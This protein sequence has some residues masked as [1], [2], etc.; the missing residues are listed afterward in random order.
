MATIE[1]DLVVTFNG[2]IYNYP[3]LRA[4]LETQGHRFLTDCDTEVLLHGYRAWGKDLPRRLTGMFA[5]ALADRSHDEL[6]VAR[7]RFGE[8]PLFLLTCGTYVAFASELRPLAAFPDLSRRVNVE[9]L[10][11]YLA[12]NYVPGNATLLAGVERLPAASWRLYSRS[13]SIGGRYWATPM[14]TVPDAN[15]PHEEVLAEFQSRFDRA[16]RLSLRSDV[17]VGLFLSGGV[18]SSLVAESATRQGNLNCAYCIDF[19]ERTHSEAEGARL[20][21]DRLGLPLDCVTLTPDALV[22]FFQ[23]VEHADDPLA[24]SSALAV[25][26]LSRYAARRNKVV[27]GGDGGDE[28]FAGYLTYQASWLQAR[29]LA[30]MPRLL[31]RGLSRVARFLPTSETKVSLSYKLRRFLRAANLPVGQAHFS[32]NGTWLPDEAATLV[33]SGP[34]RTAAFDALAALVSRFGID[35]RWS[36]HA[37]QRADLSEYL[38]NDI[39]TKTDRMSMAHGLETRAP[40]LEHELAEW[41]LSLPESLKWGCRG[42]RQGK[43]L[44]RAALR[45]AFGPAIADRPKQGFSI[46]IHSWVRGP[47]AEVVQD[48]LAPASVKEFG[49]LE[50]ERV[51][52]VVD[53]HFSGRKS[54]GFELWGLAVLLAWHRR[55]IQHPPSAPGASDV[56]ERTF[57]R[58]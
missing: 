28:L 1:G 57:P 42:P 17:P 20:V 3:E 53:F 12:L 8:K 51:R 52:R 22:D 15:T 39:L 32:W 24:D 9:A 40:F 45:R 5:F 14:E 11:G 44:L 56:W 4:E 7:D 10:G 50:P 34:P 26:T 30:H 25:W 37:L 31:R 23:L 55:R 58:R 43:Q 46:P 48:L 21:A 2:E 6:F 49:Y 33:C 18:D 29:Y 41:S 27:L 19:M 13:N 16:V 54:Y 47:L 35:D 36:L 38:P